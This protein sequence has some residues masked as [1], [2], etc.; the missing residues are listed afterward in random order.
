MMGAT[1][2][3]AANHREGP[4]VSFASCQGYNYQKPLCVLLVLPLYLLEAR[5]CAADVSNPP[6]Y[7]MEYFIQSRPSITCGLINLILFTGPY[8]KFTW[9]IT[10][11][12]ASFMKLWTVVPK[13]VSTFKVQMLR[14]I[15]ILRKGIGTPEHW[16]WSLGLGLRV[17][18]I[19]FFI[20]FCVFRV[21]LHDHVLLL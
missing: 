2:L 5:G 11:F 13:S 7:L 21:V 3:N 6:Q 8:V 1:Q 12:R 18:T 14:D 4:I 17:A 19:W 20:L 9:N 10:D 16:Q 15:F